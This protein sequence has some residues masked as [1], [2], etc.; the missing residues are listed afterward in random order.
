[1]ATRVHPV[2]RAQSETRDEYLVSN[3]FHKV[4]RNARAQ[5]LNGISEITGAYLSFGF[6]KETT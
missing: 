5:K 2:V 3:D 4:A 1:V 6:Y